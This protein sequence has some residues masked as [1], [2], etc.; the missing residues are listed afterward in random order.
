[1]ISKLIEW[2]CCEVQRGNFK[3]AKRLEKVIERYFNNYGIKSGYKLA[4]LLDG[5]YK[6]YILYGKKRLVDKKLKEL[7]YTRL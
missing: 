3:M 5:K 4:K 1:M 7:K 2:L 6:D